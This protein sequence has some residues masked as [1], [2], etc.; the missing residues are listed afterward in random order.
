MSNE[1]CCKLIDILTTLS[2]RFK[3]EKSCKRSVNYYFIIG[4]SVLT[5]STYMTSRYQLYDVTETRAFC[6][7]QMPLI[8]GSWFSN[9]R[10]T[11]F[12][13]LDQFQNF[14]IH[15]RKCIILA[16]ILHIPMPHIDALWCS[17]FTAIW[18]YILS[19]ILQ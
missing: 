6:W 9:S 3:M 13:V 8:E 5:G 18:V 1:N 16:S 2:T 17:R 15:P 11:H 4:V 7:G 19:M 14:L 12:P 10:L